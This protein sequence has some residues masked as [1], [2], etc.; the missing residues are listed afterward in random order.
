MEGELKRGSVVQC[1]SKDIFRASSL[2]LLC[3]SDKHVGRDLR[4]LR[5]GKPL[6]PLL[7]VRVPEFAKVV[8]ADGYHRLCAAC[9][10]Y[11]DAVVPC[12]IA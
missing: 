3:V 9:L 7:L 8:V 6:S 12:K 4:K 5:A 10:A 2:S 11:E 1:Q